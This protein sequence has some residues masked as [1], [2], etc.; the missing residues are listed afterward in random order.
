MLKLITI[1]EASKILKVSKQRVNKYILTKRI[2]SAIKIGNIWIMAED[3]IKH[4][5]PKKSGR[6]KLL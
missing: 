4:F 2:K 5:K 6:P 3:E 1:G